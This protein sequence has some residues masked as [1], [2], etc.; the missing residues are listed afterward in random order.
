VVWQSWA[1]CSTGACAD[2]AYAVSTGST[3]GAPIYAIATPEETEASPRIAIDQAGRPLVMFSR[4]NGDGYFDV[5]VVNAPDGNSFGAEVN[6]T[7]GTDTVDQWMP[8]G[9]TFHP[10]TGLPHLTFTEVLASTEPL[11]TEVYHAEFVPAR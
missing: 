5:F 8:Y 2:L 6:V 7:P 3:F 11:D 9:L 10:D 1:S 4:A